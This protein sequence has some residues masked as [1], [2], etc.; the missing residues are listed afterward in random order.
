MTIFLVFLF[1]YVLSQF[2]RT[3]LAVIAPEMA[4]D[5]GIAAAD[6]GVLSGVWFAAFAIGQF[7]VGWALD[8]FGPRRTMPVIMLAAVAGALLLAAAQ[9]RIACIVAMALIG[10]GCA[11]IYM[12]ALYYFGRMYQ[13]SRFAFLASLLIA[14]GSVGNLLGATPLALAAQQFGWRGTLAA[15]GALTLAAALVVAVMVEDPPRREAVAVR[16]DGGIVA[17]IGELL[18]I[19]ALW[20]MLPLIA[21]SYA[22]VIAERGL[23][24]GPYLSDVHGLTPVERG[25][26]VLAMAIAM[27]AG[28]LV[29]GAL[30]QPLRTRKW[31]VVAGSVA[32][33]TAFAALGSLQTSTVSAVALLSLLGFA[34]HTYAVLMAHGRS[35]IPDHMLGRGIT[36]L[37]ALFIG[38]AGVLQPISGA[39]FE[40]IRASSGAA[41]AYAA[42]HLLFATLL[43]VTTL[44]YLRA[45]DR[46]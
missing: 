12:G 19:R 34:G 14:V 44:I 25:N 33:V 42:I 24:V 39:L 4:R 15:I 40:H 8:H 5:L 29:L 1:G 46:M 7:P 26:G 17:G 21:V 36:M 22:V 30:D 31:I 43:A 6:L 18:S 45:E 32:T 28:A 35:F 11:P 13:A 38:G 2:Y 9:S 37:N 10:L 3:F 41:S 16:N 23:W 27:S 20:P